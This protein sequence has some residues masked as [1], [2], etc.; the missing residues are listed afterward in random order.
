MCASH[1]KQG[2]LSLFAALQHDCNF[3]AIDKGGDLVV[4]AADRL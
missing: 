2:A 3:S 1:R 4:I